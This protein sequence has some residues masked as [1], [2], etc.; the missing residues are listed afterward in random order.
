MA[1]VLHSRDRSLSVQSV[2][3]VIDFPD[4]ENQT[5]NDD[6][7][8]HRP[9]ADPPDPEAKTRARRISAGHGQHFLYA[10]QSAD[11]N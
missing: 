2:A 10:Q 9:G 6:H 5:N 8:S 7:P 1:A 3:K 11:E 4:R